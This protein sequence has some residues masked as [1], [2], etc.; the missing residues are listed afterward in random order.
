MKASLNIPLRE[1]D[2]VYILSLIFESPE[3]FERLKKYLL[4]KNQ[5]VSILLSYFT[6]GEAEESIIGKALE[7]IPE[8]K[9]GDVTSTGQKA[10]ASSG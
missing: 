9:E 6:S 2:H 3:E 5:R 1:K 10:D 8:Q 4:I 7:K